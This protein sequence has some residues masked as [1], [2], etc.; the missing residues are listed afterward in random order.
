MQSWMGV[1]WVHKSTFNVAYSR[2]DFS[3]PQDT[4]SLPIL[5][6][7]SLERKVQPLLCPGPSFRLRCALGKNSWFHYTRNTY[8]HCD[9]QFL[10]GNSALGRPHSPHRTKVELRP[11]TLIKVSA[12]SVTAPQTPLLLASSTP[13]WDLYLAEE[14]FPL[15]T[16]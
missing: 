7:I 12:S 8:K 10:E 16:A 3:Y 1:V 2:A 9:H 14:H 5:P 4:Q 6:C 11:C 15:N 13:W